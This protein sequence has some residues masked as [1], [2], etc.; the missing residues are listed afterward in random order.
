MSY[1]Y[2]IS[3]IIY[4]QFNSWLLPIMQIATAIGSVE[5]YLL[6]ISA[7]YWCVNTRLGFRLGLILTL[8]QGLNDSLKIAFHS[9]RPY[10]VSRKV[11]PYASYSSFGIPSGHSQNAVCIWGY[12]ASFLK[13][14]WAA[15][16]VLIFIISLSRIYLGA[17]F[18]IDVVVGWAVGAII[19]TSFLRLEP[20]TAV[21]FQNLSLQKQI[22]IS[23]L[24]SIGLL[25]LYS[26][27]FMALDGWQVPPSWANSAMAATG[28]PIDPLN[29][30]DIL[31]SAGALF[32][33]GAGYSWFHRK[34]G[35]SP[36]GP[37]V[38]RLLRF[39]LGIAGLVLI[40]YGIGAIGLRQT[41]LLSYGIDYLRAVLASIWVTA[42]A[43][44]L[45]MKA[46]LDGKKI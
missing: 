9:P 38:V 15:A 21:F 40:W 16:S 22:L 3:F 31:G 11:I 8:S 19:L 26:L 32:G 10:W 36:K 25:A 6:A 42:A 17:H 39:F 7:I 33:M 29:H 14:A 43:P 27:S 34:H 37:V 41:Q 2:Q 30:G 18:P 1:D 12:L 13:K 20:R 24:A 28:V 35:F 5:F 44:I 46:G 45:F 23:F 4:L